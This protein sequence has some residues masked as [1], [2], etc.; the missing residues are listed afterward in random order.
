M[1]DI[2]EKKQTFRKTN[3]VGTTDIVEKNIE[4]PEK[5]IPQG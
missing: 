2:I 3:P 4:S 5:Q 1:T